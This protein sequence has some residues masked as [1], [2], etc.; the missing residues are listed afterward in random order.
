MAKQRKPEDGHERHEHQEHKTH[1]REP[2]HERPR[3]PHGEGRERAVFLQYLAKKWIG[4]ALPTAEAYSR[5]LKQWRQLPGSIVTPA[6]DVT[7]ATSL[8]A[9]RK[10]PPAQGEESKS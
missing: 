1:E 6:T 8:G 2:E 4:S 10:R 3:H 9:Q 7:P 5:A